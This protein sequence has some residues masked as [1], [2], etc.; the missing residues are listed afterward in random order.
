MPISI[1]LPVSDLAWAAGFIDGEGTISVYGRSDRINEFR[2]TI[3]AVNTKRAA[4][5]KL[6]GMFGGTVHD[7]HRVTPGKNWKPSF[8]WTL[9]YEKAAAAIRLLLPFLVIKRPQA[10]LALEARAFVGQPG[11]KR[12]E[13]QV[14]SLRAISNRFRALN[15]KGKG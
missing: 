10:E 15:L 7:M 4:L 14:Q 3:Q 9:S 1:E 8:Y 2:V 13:S 5:E 6:Q 11:R 12:G